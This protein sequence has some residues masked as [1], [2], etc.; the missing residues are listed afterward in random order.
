[1]SEPFFFV[2]IAMLIGDFVNKTE[3]TNYVQHC[4]LE[5]EFTGPTCSTKWRFHKS[6]EEVADTQNSKKKKCLLQQYCTIA[7]GSH[8]AISTIGS[9][10][11]IT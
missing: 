8:F 5:L 10:S 11:H 6:T 1:M 2:L 7:H 9:L 3:M 4:F